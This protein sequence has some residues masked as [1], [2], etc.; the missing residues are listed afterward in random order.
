M[1]QDTLEYYL[2]Q[3]R[4]IAE[5]REKKV[6]QSIRK[7]YKTLLKDLQHF[8][9][10]EYAEYAKDDVLSFEILN[11]KRQ[12]ARFIE[13][14]TKVVE[15]WYPSM[16]KQAVGVVEEVYKLAYDGMVDAVKKSQDIPALK[17]ALKGVK[18]ATPQTVKRAVMNPL[19]GLTLSDT[20]EKNRQTVIYEIKQQ[21]NIGLVN[22]DRYSTMAKRI[23]DR[24]NIDYRKAMLIVRTET[25]RVQE[26]GFFDSGEDL[27]S[28][29]EKGKTAMRLK[30][31]WNSME[32]ERVRDT[33]R[34]NHRRMNGK[35]A[36][37]EEDFDLGNGVKAKAPGMSGS[38]ANDCNCRCFVTY[39]LVE[40]EEVAKKLQAEKDA[41][42]A[43]AKKKAE[44]EAAKVE[45]ISNVEEMEL[46]TKVSDIDKDAFKAWYD[47][48]TYPLK[49]FDK[50][51]E[52]HQ[53]DTVEDL[54]N[55]LTK[56]K[57]E[58]GRAKIFKAFEE[59]KGSSASEVV[60]DAYT[61]ARKDA[62]WW[63]KSREEADNNLRDE[64]G[65]V[66][67][68]APEAEKRAIHRYTGG[69]YGAYNQPLSGYPDGWYGDFVGP[70][71]CSINAQ[72]EAENIRRMTE[73]I[74][75]SS[76][77]HDLWL[78]RGS[79]ANALESF[80]GLDEGTLSAMS[81]KELQQFVGTSNRMYSFISCGSAKGQGFSGEVVMNFYCPQGSKMMYVEPI[82]NFG[83]GAGLSWD[84]ISKQSDFGRE[85]ET[86]L[87]RGGSYTITKMEKSG[88]TIFVDFE[89]HPEQGYDLIQQF[90]DVLGKPTIV[91][92]TDVLGE[93]AADAALKKT[94]QE[95]ISLQTKASNLDID[96][97]VKQVQSVSSMDKQDVLYAFGEATQY[98]TK[99]TVEDVLDSAIENGIISEI[100]YEKLKKKFKSG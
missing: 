60:E 85:L 51:F 9:A 14:A 64:A 93:T 43:A 75:R 34:A 57:T 22:G 10:D 36:W 88:G 73:I 13:E 33:A 35:T 77:D 8:I 65:R 40:D 86:I 96:S 17:K 11:Q 97:F 82:S 98:N 78:Q 39:D 66:W 53:N 32:D 44:A 12:Y 25:H 67:R 71:N 37:M 23:T 69:S 24:V 1:E 45:K 15:D 7:D 16:S 92:A 46:G 52:K 5:H 84:G 63:A 90:D 48:T 89:L 49:N 4:R 81:E 54:L 20:M 19:S 18:A 91:A 59:A 6:M 99:A 50:I 42:I 28:T 80:L 61:Q 21:L 56:G 74:S 26:Q 47:E 58:A 79:G 55:D 95:A 83:R 76:Y 100:E 87:Q 31:T 70:G 38:A 3:I 2:S 30:K 29:L 72:G 62:A 41:A 68:E 27:N 94:T